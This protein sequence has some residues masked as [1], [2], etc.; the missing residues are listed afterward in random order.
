MKDSLEKL[1]NKISELK[2]GKQITHK[3][4]D[5]VGAVIVAKEHFNIEEVEY[6]SYNDINSLI[7]ASIIELEK[8][9]CEYLLI[10]DI[11]PSE[12]VCKKID[13][14][15]KS[16]LNIILV[17]HHKTAMA[18]N[19]YD[20]AIVEIERNGTLNS[21]TNLL[22]ELLKELNIYTNVFVNEFAEKVR[23]YDTWDWTRLKDDIPNKL[24]TLFRIIG[25]RDFEKRF[26]DKYRTILL[27]P[28]EEELI[29]IENKRIEMYVDKKIDKV[30]IFTIN[31]YKAGYVFAEE[32][33]N[34]VAV[35][36][37]TNF[38]VDFAMVF[39]G[40][41][42]VS[43]RTNKENVDVSKIASIYGGGGHSKSSGFE[44]PEH[45]KEKFLMN[46]M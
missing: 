32:N 40:I 36:I 24:N 29:A 23:R 20:W 37:Y 13:K 45:F 14:A 38:N 44:V 6:A 26:T 41:D 21:G 30:K 11:S 43:L 15:F 22:L 17:D 28:W 1:F 4:L 5:G 18:L 27:T 12:E 34:D 9:I 2:K 39:S 8:G 31:G 3:D 33:I 25:E 16:G 35:M 42:K 46:F 19:S 10:T 7:N